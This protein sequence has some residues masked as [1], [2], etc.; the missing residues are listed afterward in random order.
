MDENNSVAVLI[1]INSNEYEFGIEVD[2]W[3]QMTTFEK[4]EFLT[5]CEMEARE[6]YC[7]SRT[8]VSVTR[9]DGTE[10]EI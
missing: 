9:P 1:Q 8:W 2:E 5:D 3:D 4:D 6:R 7:E 10:E